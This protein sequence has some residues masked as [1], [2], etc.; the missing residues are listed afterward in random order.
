MKTKKST[1]KPALSIDLLE[2]VAGMLRLLAHPHRLRVIEFLEDR[3]EGAP[4]KDIMEHVALPHA[5]T[6]QHLNQMKRRPPWRRQQSLVATIAVVR[7]TRFIPMAR[8]MRRRQKAIST[9]HLWRICALTSKRSKIAANQTFA[10]ASSIAAMAKAN[11]S[12]VSFSESKRPD[13]PP[14]PASIFVLSKIGP[15]LVMVARKRA[16]HFAGSQ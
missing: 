9:L 7:N 15:P 2:R 11:S 1:A 6:S 14:W 4:V 10:F 3:D 16:T 12:A 13:A 8:L 5:A